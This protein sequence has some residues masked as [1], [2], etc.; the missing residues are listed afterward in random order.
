MKLIIVITDK[1]MFNNWVRSPQ[2]HLREGYMARGCCV[3]GSDY[4]E[5]EDASVWV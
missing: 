2:W 3:E 1:V 5:K 4:C